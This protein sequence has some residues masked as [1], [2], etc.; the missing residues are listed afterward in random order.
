M[1]FFLSNPE[2]GY[3]MCYSKRSYFLRRNSALDVPP[4]W[5]V[6]KLALFFFAVALSASLFGIGGI[7][8]NPWPFRWFAIAG[9]AGFISWLFDSAY[10]ELKGKR[11]MKQL[12][13]KSVICAGSL[14]VR[15]GFFYSKIQFEFY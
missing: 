3:L 1:L 7:G 8:P 15:A 14:L 2:G 4:E 9:T 11:L 12:S 10:V 5:L 13:A 6:R